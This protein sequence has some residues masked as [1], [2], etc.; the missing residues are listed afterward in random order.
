MKNPTEAQEQEIAD[1]VLDL[2][3]L[4][5]F[6]DTSAPAVAR[7]LIRTVRS[8]EEARALVDSMLTEL[9]EWPGPASMVARYRQ[10]FWRQQEPEWLGRYRA[11]IKAEHPAAPGD[12]ADA[13]G[14]P[15]AERLSRHANLDQG[16]KPQ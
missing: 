12:L 10:M 2:Y 3:A 4:R 15:L 8:T 7:I 16:S 14:H 5:Y 1:L 11:S 6:P 13:I 9:D